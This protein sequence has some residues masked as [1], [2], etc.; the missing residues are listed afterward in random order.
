LAATRSASEATVRTE[1]EKFLATVAV[2][3]RQVQEAIETAKREGSRTVPGPVVFRLYDTYGLPIQVIRE[4][5]EEERFGL[6]EPGFEAALA[7][8]RERSRAATGALKKWK[9]ELQQSLEKELEGQPA[10]RFEGYERLSIE[11]VKV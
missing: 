11:G 2:G 7:E 4:I 3:S 6:D 8:Q 1:E 9:L 10:T 5:A